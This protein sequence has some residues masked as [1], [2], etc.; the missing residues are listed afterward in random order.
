MKPKFALVAVTVILAASLIANAYLYVQQQSFAEHKNALQNQAAELRDEVSNLQNETKD[1]QNQLSQL[2]QTDGPKL[3]T[4]LGGRDMR[5]SYPGQDIRLSISGEVWNVGT[6]AA[7][8]CRVNVT[9]YRHAT[10]VR[11]ELIELGTIEAG[12][13]K[14]VVTNVYYGG[15]A[16]TNWTLI[17]ECD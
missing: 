11:N 4:R 16:L 13:F 1:L 2:D 3:V 9:L 5:F 12:S 17:P 8:N 7:Y 6:S 15:G 10:A 14:D